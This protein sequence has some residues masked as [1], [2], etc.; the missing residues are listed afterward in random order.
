MLLNAFNFL[1]FLDF[2]TR[3]HLPLFSNESM[4]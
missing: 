1:A 3:T 2:S 4:S